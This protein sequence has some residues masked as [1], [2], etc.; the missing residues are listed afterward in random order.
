M[1]TRSNAVTPTSPDHFLTDN[2]WFARL[3]AAL[4]EAG[5]RPGH[6][7][8]AWSRVESARDAVERA[9][10]RLTLLNAVLSLNE[11]VRAT[12]ALR[13]LD[14]RDVPAIARITKTAEDIVDARIRNGV[15]R[16]RNS[17]TTSTAPQG[18]CRAADGPT[19][20]QAEP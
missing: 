18:R 11:P 1:K 7:A 4:L 10:I 8:P 6:S 12:V 15:A 14:G 19:G 13:L 16:I 9:E 5:P 20:P 17:L 2:E 3:M